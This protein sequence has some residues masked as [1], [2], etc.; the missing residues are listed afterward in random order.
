MAAPARH[1]NDRV[2]NL[3]RGKLQRRGPG[4]GH[5]AP[6]PWLLRSPVQLDPR[7]ARSAA[8]RRPC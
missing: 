4:A 8:S 3:P 1:R 6:G 5:A 7:P 2:F